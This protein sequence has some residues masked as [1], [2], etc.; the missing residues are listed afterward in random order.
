MS[1]SE[2]GEWRAVTMTR[3]TPRLLLIGGAEERSEESSVLRHFLWMVGGAS[4]RLLLC[5]AA[6][7]H[8]RETLREYSR[9]FTAMGVQDIFEEPLEDR[10]AAEEEDLLAFLAEASGV[11]FSG[12]DQMQMTS[13]VAG[14]SF[15]RVLRER[16]GEG[17]VV[18][19]GTSAGAAAMSGTMIA[20][21]RSRGTIRK[22]DVDLAPGLGFWRDTV[23]DTHFNQRGRV[24]R[25]LTVFAQNP[26]VLGVGIDE[27]TAV[28]VDVG[29]RLQ[30]VGSGAL[31]L[32]HG[33][34]SHTNAAQAGEDEVMALSGVRVDVLPGGYGMDL[35][36]MELHLP[37]DGEK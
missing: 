33:Q 9:V 11:F 13:L 30:V 36:S 22:S 20:G 4:A 34:P 19:A 6:T 32:F 17:A 29:V 21:G 25:L 15:G 37:G 35:P 28:E 27:D 14:T 10:G 24:H 1:G 5:S 18:V 3:K 8:H 12:G 16:F 2:S 31:M 26:Q 7:N 23:I